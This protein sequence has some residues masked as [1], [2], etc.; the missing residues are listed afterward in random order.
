MARFG[1]ARGAV[2]SSPSKI[3]GTAWETAVVYYLQGTWPEAHRL[4][5]G[6]VN[7]RADIGGVPGWVIECKAPTGSLALGGI[8]KTTEA[9]AERLG[10]GHL[11]VVITK[12]VRQ[13]TAEAMATVP[14]WLWVMLAK[15]EQAP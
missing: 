14:L 13:S 8:L 7:D 1:N 15:L 3:R 5:P 4:A 12:R 2:T 11:P 10:P 6:G 9:R